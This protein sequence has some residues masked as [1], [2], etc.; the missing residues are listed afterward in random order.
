MMT[1]FPTPKLNEE[2]QALLEEIMGN[3]HTIGIDYVQALV[4]KFLVQ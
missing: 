4:G 3:V 2:Q 1:D